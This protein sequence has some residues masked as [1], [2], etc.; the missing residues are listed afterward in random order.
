MSD[1]KFFKLLG[2]LLVVPVILAAFAG[3]RYRYPCQDPANWDKD[4]CKAPICETTRTCPS[5]IFKGNES[6]AP[7][8]TPKPILKK[9]C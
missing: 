9:G 1:T 7:A 3:D 8:Q 2:L 5:H 4:F 6:I